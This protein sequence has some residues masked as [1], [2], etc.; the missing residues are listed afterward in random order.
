MGAHADIEPG[1][2]LDIDQ[3]VKAVKP[4]GSVTGFEGRIGR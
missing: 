4:G 3:D 2:D 1:S